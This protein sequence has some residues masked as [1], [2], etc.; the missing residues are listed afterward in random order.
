MGR[1]SHDRE[2]VEELASHLAMQ[3]EDNIRSG[4]K[5]QEARRQAL[6]KAGSL[7]AGLE[8]YREQSGFPML[9]TSLQDIRYGLRMLR[10]N[11]GF[12]A[13]A[14]ITLA[15]GIG[16]N[17]A[18]FSVVHAVL[19]KSLPYPDPERLVEVS[20]YQLHNGEQSVS[21][22]DFREWQA[23]AQV[24]DGIAAIRPHH[25]VLTG[26]GAPDL[27]RAGEVTSDFFPLLGTRTVLGRTFVPQDDRPEAKRTVVLSYSFW[28]TRLGSDHAILGRDLI[29]DDAPYIIIGVLQ[30]DFRFFQQG[31]DLYVPAG[32]R[33]ADR[34]WLLRG[35]HQGLAALA[36]LGA[37]VSL[38]AANSSLDTIMR[39]LEKQYPASN[40]GQRAR[41]ITLYSARVGDV[42]RSFLILLVASICV[43]LIACSNVANLSLARAACR[44]REFAVRAAIGARRSRLVRQLLTESLV[45]AG[46]GGLLGLACARLAMRPLVLLAP[47]NIPRLDETR[48]DASV[49]VFTFAAA[50]FAAIVVGL[51]PALQSSR[52]DLTA[53]LGE[54]GRKVSSGKRGQ[55]LRAGLLVA[56][57]SL[58]AVL[59]VASGLLIRS[60]MGALGVDAGFKADHLLALDVNL[61][62]SRYKT[63]PQ[64]T[65]FLQ[66]AMNKLRSLPGVE[67]ASAVFCPPLVGTC[68]DSVFLIGDRSRPPVSQEPRAAFNIAE[69]KYFEAMQVPL[70]AGRRFGIVDTMESPKV[71]LINETMAKRWWPKESPL[72]KRI[73]Q[74]DANAPPREIVGVVGDLKED[75]IDQP[76]WPEVFEPAA[77]NP[78][79]A[80]TLVMRTAGEP[81]A[82][83]ASAEDIIHQIDP[84][85]PLSHVQPMSAYL[86]ASLARREFET[87]LLGIFSGLAL[88]LAAVG[89]YGLAGYMVAQRTHEIGIRI[90]LGAQ[91]RSVFALVMSFGLKLSAC[92]VAIGIIAALAVTHGLE[93]LLFGVGERDP[94]TFFGVTVLLGTIA[95]L[96][97]YFPARRATQVDPMIALGRE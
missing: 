4:M 88:L 1:R 11:P 15:L 76:Q 59:V 64:Q 27:L 9:E 48:I 17:T 6:V 96:A 35:N 13:V 26:Q 14:L 42:Q 25:F 77:Q 84:N 10:K 46:I 30:P 79:P 47:P 70:L 80:M 72:G 81:T 41:V 73:M 51:L 63:D 61:P 22:M 92:G 75:G 36:R 37:G 57:I 55:R 91:K 97:C 95:L 18:V 60:L 24:F 23:Q 56:Q 45:L 53:S 7:A 90:A 52:V 16:A 87:L 54:A 28:R 49:F 3:V 2:L 40:D 71:V 44:V 67:S 58:A 12:T 94:L 31:I 8:R 33:G 68:W 89:I 66:Q 83:A 93:N 74:G 20:E 21:W 5:P 34:N 29:L 50:A 32:L 65:I 39:R 62:A 38:A 43:L 19:L 69:P 86:D 82:M 85:Q 78:M